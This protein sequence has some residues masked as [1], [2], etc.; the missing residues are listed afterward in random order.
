MLSSRAVPLHYG[1][2]AVTLGDDACSLFVVTV[3]VLS[4]AAELGHTS[5]GKHRLN[6]QT[7]MP[8]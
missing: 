7:C 6:Q 3:Q 2:T 4:L 1:C 5:V 8:V